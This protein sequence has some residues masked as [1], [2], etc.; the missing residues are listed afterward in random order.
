MGARIG[1]RTILT[2]LATALLAVCPAALSASL[3]THAPITTITHAPPFETK[4]HHVRFKFEANKPDVKFKCRVDG[5]DYKTCSSPRGVSAGKGHHKFE[6]Y[7]IWAGV[8][9]PPDGASWKV[10]GG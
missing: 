1:A 10:V 9:G 3:R 4:K 7:G 6:V 2:L 5:G 8:P